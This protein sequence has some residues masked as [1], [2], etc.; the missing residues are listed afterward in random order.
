MPDMQRRPLLRGS[1]ALLSTALWPTRSLRAQEGSTV[2]LGIG[3]WP[4]YFGQGLRQHGVFAHLVTEAFRREGLQV[5]YQLMPWKRA[6]SLVESGALHGSPG[7]AFS[8]ERAR[9]FHYSAPVIIS[10]DVLFYAR[11]RPLNVRGLADLEGRQI[12]ATTG[13]HYGTQIEQLEQQGRLRLDRAPSDELSLRKLLLG[14][15]DGVLMNRE[16]GLE[17]LRSR[18]S[19]QERAGIEHSERALSE[20]PSHMLMSRALPEV[21]AL[22]QAFNRGLAK[23]QREGLAK[24][25]LDEANRG[26]YAGVAR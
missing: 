2:R 23:L 24:R 13:Y 25:W 17:L 14:R 8:E 19:A 4:P 5:E 18:F 11:E 10:R 6:L 16:V 26:A 20:K 7:W 3:E 9:L 15:L 12:G 22:L 21:P 1:A